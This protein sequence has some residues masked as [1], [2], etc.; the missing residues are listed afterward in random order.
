MNNE[1]NNTSQLEDAE[2]LKEIP[3][4][5]RRYAENRTLTLLVFMVIILLFSMATCPLAFGIAMFQKGKMALGLV[6]IAVVVA[7]YIVYAVLIIRKFGG[8]NRGRLDQL[9]DH[10]I[11]GREGTASI[12]KIESSKKM[13]WVSLAVSVVSFGLVIGTMNLGM[14][15]YIAAKYIQPVMALYYVPH[16]VF[17]WYFSQRPKFGPVMLLWPTLYT[18][19]AILIIVG[20]PIFFT[21]QFGVVLNMFL[22]WFGYGVLTY[23]I[24]H[25]YGQYALKKLKD[26]AHL[27][28]GPASGV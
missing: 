21:G 18:M 14:K 13:K 26:I 24:G 28:G 4:W 2:K 25:L 19:H 16:M 17:L 7:L 3:K 12:A 6:C 15:G 10:W 20:V 9:I 11:Y 1:D 8:K 23:V 27:D 5:T 22:P